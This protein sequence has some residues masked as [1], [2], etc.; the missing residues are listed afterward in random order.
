MKG[1]AYKIPIPLARSQGTANADRMAC[2]MT[3][4]YASLLR[5]DPPL[6]VLRGESDPLKVVEDD[7]LATFDVPA[8]RLRFWAETLNGA[9]IDRASIP[10][11][12][13]GLAL[14]SY[15]LDAVAR[16]GPA[17]GGLALGVGLGKT[18]SACAYAHAIGAQSIILICPLNAM[19]TWHK[20]WQMLPVKPTMCSLDSAHN[21]KG[22]PPVD[23]II[24][25]EAH[26][27][28]RRQADRTKEAH[29]LRLKAR[30]GLALTGTLLHAG[31]EK[32]LSVL[33]LCTPGA[34]LF[35]NTWAAG[36]HFRCLVRG[37]HGTSLAKPVKEMRDA[38]HAY[39]ARHVVALTPDSAAVKAVLQLPGQDV[40][41][42]RIAEPWQNIDQLAAS[43]VRTAISIGDPLPSASAIAHDLAAWGADTKTDWVL[44]N[45]ADE[46]VVIFAHYTETLDL[47]AQKLRDSGITFVRVDGSVTGPE[48]IAAQT[49]FQSGKVQV[50]LG[51]MTAAGISMDLYR[52]PYSIAIDHPWKSDVYAQ[53]L[54]RTH[55]RGQSQ[56]CHHW[57][58]I[59]NEFQ[60]KVVRKL[61]AGNDF[62]AETAEWQEIK[63]Q[64][65]LT[66]KTPA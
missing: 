58:L 1:I 52:T 60:A 16:L 13:G 62:N 15:Q 21:L 29:K 22:H 55:R 53:A 47:M 20:N 9:K 6:G 35:S 2:A 7:M 64:I 38:F 44:Q 49:E 34:S 32:A 41:D 17:G 51:Q 31:I 33:D 66:S 4:A 45:L 57:D 36:E 26:L 46:P 3:A 25:D 11:E 59:A 43:L 12:L 5:G 63:A 27:Q 18:I 14:S 65:D 28:G 48:R 54:G 56:H 10:T 23:L 42:I 39:L 8:D 40:S 30:S 24:F 50:F 37:E 61:R 19:P